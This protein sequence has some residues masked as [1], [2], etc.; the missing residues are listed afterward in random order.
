MATVNDQLNLINTSL[1]KLS[2]VF[3]ALLLPVDSPFTNTTVVS[4]VWFDRRTFGTLKN[5]FSL[6]KSHLLNIFFRCI[7]FKLVIWSIELTLFFLTNLL[8][9]LRG[10][11]TLISDDLTQQKKYRSYRRSCWQSDR[12]DI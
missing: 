11:K 8:G 3:R 10:Q 12:W 4:S 2:G 6:S 1:T 5:N 7:S 9:Q